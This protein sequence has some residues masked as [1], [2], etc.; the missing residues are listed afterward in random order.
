MV[1]VLRDEEQGL[2]PDRQQQLGGME[3]RSIRQGSLTPAAPTLEYL[4]CVPEV[5]QCLAVTA[6][7]ADEAFRPAMPL[8]GL[9]ALLFGAVSADKLAQ[10]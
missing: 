4:D 10:A 6:L 1:L 8:Y 3:N 2:E 7:W 9:S 5:G